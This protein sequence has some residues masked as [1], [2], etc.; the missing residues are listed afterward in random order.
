M[1]RPSDNCRVRRSGGFTLIEVL[2][3]TV[4]AAVVLA[5]LHSSYVA[6]SVAVSRC[7]SRLQAGREMRNALERIA[8][9]LRCSVWKAPASQEA[10]QTG[11]VVSD[12]A[13]FLGG[14]QEVEFLLLPPAG[15]P[16]RFLPGLARVR[17]RFSAADGCLRRAEGSVL[18]SDGGE[19]ADEAWSVVARGLEEVEFAFFNGSE[20]RGTWDSN[21]SAGAPRA[22]RVALARRVQDGL[23]MRSSVA[24]ATGVT[25]SPAS[26]ASMTKRPSGAKD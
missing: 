2:V 5:A 8:E 21:L 3:A 13:G 10:G 15:R 1:F 4:V 22:V 16:G 26:A 23:L 19:N 12:R 17:Y 25:L 20:W 6:A 18:A 9:E 7:E 14:G 11:V 24:A